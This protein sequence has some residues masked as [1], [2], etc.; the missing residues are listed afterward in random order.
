MKRK[1]FILLIFALLLSSVIRVRFNLNEGLEF[2]GFW[3]TPPFTFLSISTRFGHLLTST[4]LGYII[5]ILFGINEYKMTAKRTK[6]YEYLT[7]FI[8]FS[9]AITGYEISQIISDFN[10]NF[11]GRHVHCGPL[12][13]ITGLVILYRD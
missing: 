4:F 12:L 10:G 1:S 11:N 8:I 5:Y 6:R 2:Y 13:F 7:W 3:V 9:V